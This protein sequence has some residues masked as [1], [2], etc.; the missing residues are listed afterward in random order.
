MSYDLFISYSRRDNE[1]GQV[2]ALA[3]QVKTA[4]RAFAGREL[5]VFFDVRE[6]HGMDDWRQKIQRSLR[7]SHLFLAVLSPNYLASPYCRWEWE[8]YVRYEAMRQCLGEGVAPVFFVTLPDAADPLTD[9]AVKDWLDEIYRR[10]T[11]DLRPWH[12]AGEKALQQAH[13]KETLEK[14]HTSV[15]ERLDRAERAGRSP[16]NVLRHNPQF[17]GRVRELTDLRNALTKNKLGIVGARQ[18]GVMA[19]VQGVGGMGKTELA[20]AYAHAFAW[21]YPGGRWQLRCEHVADLRVALLQLAGPMGFEFSEEENKSLALAFER[22][23]RELDRRDRC[24]LVLDNVSD[25]G[26]LEPGYLD[27]LP[28]DGRVDLIATTR[29]APASI[30]GSA[31]DQTFVAVDELPEE[32]ALA[33]LRSHQP[34][35]RF[36]NQTEDDEAGAIARLLEGFTLAIETAAIYLGR[37]AGPDACRRFR[38]RLQTKLLEESE[39]AAGDRTVAVRHRERLLGKT[40]AFTFETLSPE[41][42]HLLTLASLLPADAIALPWLQAVG[43]NA[44]RAFRDD[45]E[46][47]SSAFRQTVD[48][49]L[50][51]RLFQTTGEMDA[52]GRLLVG[53]MH[54]LVQE[55]VKGEYQADAATLESALLQHIRARAKF[56]W[57]GWVAQEHRWELGPLAACAWQWLGRESSDG[58]DLAN[59]AA[60]PLWKLGNVAEAEQLLHRAL[61]ISEHNDNS[62][63]AS[64][65]N[66]LGLVYADL[67]QV[68]RAIGYHEQ[69]L[70]IARKIGD[71]DGEGASLGNLGLACTR[72][73]QVER[74]IGYYEQQLVIVR[75]IGD[76]DGEGNA[77]GGL[78]IAYYRLSQFK[79]AIGY[80]EQQLVIVREIGD[81]HGEG[82][83]L[84][85]LGLAYYRLGQFKRAIG[86]YEQALVIARKIGHLRGEGNALGGL[87]ITYAD[88]GQVERAIGLLE[89]AVRIG[90]EIKDPRIVEFFTA[91]LE[92]LCGGGPTPHPKKPPELSRKPGLALGRHAEALADL[93]AAIRLDPNDAGA[94]VNRGLTYA[95]LGR[96]AEALADY[97]AAIRL[98]PNHAQ[99]HYRRGRTYTAL[100]R[101]G[102]ALADYDAAIR[103]DPNYADAHVN[104]GNIYLALGRHGEAL[105]DYDAAIRLD[106]NHAWAH[107]NKGVLHKQRGEWDDA[108]QAF[109][110]AAR[111]GNATDG[112][113]QRNGVNFDRQDGS[114]V[115]GR[116]GCDE[117]GAYAHLARHAVNCAEWRR[118]QDGACRSGARTGRPG[119]RAG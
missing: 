99:A 41:T 45:P 60:V 81:L 30:P 101:H 54:R 14:L 43:T 88:L 119:V 57:D 94:H 87:G 47:A 90:H 97:D 118:T 77:M 69:A 55:Y 110:I 74:A 103:I 6:I 106:P 36:V 76:R 56:L 93:D 65:L 63:V 19:T 61:A 8:D 44:V 85:N 78:G 42:I 64:I 18:P 22:V 31:Q 16:A 102:E 17:V 7:D 48:L 51:L 117:F 91:Q 68:E 5:P 75:E 96:H 52:N 20:L 113:D 116:T 105:G 100:Y 73:G 9:R 108:L 27:R 35:G 114:A 72:L 98:D 66:S 12:D 13:V 82:N 80:Y 15:R 86:Y 84:N 10:Q 37:H 29:L 67:G 28:R 59:Q 39:K 40:L 32:D 71:P 107:L 21:D 50:G 104:R 92:R 115:G 26:L 2:A 24:L 11:F 23:L 1:R 33:L 58:A 3:E 111:L 109:E 95:A 53:R 25:P 49:L 38:E 70:V 79:R 89:Q 112:T 34:E 62:N 4:F 46:V 83:A